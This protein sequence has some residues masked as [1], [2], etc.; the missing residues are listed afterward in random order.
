MSYIDVN[1]YTC[2]RSAESTAEW[3]QAAAQITYKVLQITHVTVHPHISPLFPIRITTHRTKHPGSKKRPRPPSSSADPVLERVVLHVEGMHCTTCSSAVEAILKASRG[4]TSALVDLLSSRAVV[5]FDA[6]RGVGP[7]DFVQAVEAAGFTATLAADNGQEDH[8]R[9]VL[10]RATRAYRALFLWSLVFTIPVFLIEMVLLQV[11]GRARRG[12]A[13]TPVGALSLAEFLMWVLTTPC[14]FIVGGRFHRGAL[15]AIRRRRANMDVLVSTG[16]IAAYLYSVIA[17]VIAIVQRARD[18]RGPEAAVRYEGH[19]RHMPA[20][21]FETS[22]MLISFVLLGKYLESKAKAR[23]SDAISS[24]LQMSPP[25]AI[26]IEGG[27]SER[28]I[29]TSLV[30]RGD[31]LRVLPGARVPVDGVVVSGRSEVDES[32]LTGESRPIRKGPGDEVIGG[33]QNLPSG[34]LVIRATRVGSD[35]ALAQISKLVQDAQLSRAPIQAYADQISA[36][37]VPFVLLA[38]LLTFLGWLIAGELE[39]YPAA[40]V[41]K[42]YSR[43]VFALLFGISVVVVACPCALGLG[44]LY[45]GSNARVHTSISCF[46]SSFSA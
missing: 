35:S 4:V 27:E 7:R 16:T 38:A 29:L 44:E 42:N 45:M 24:L 32:L 10:E 15:R 25:E 19:M 46:R 22:A 11:E 14:L 6:A 43:F 12:L 17:L 41:P 8:A 21:F 23:A 33:T 9:R 28:P 34:A 39:A 5:E 37:F 1:E 26:L 30:H 31:I 13:G 36:Y 3:H 40:W 20:T 18:A 2:P